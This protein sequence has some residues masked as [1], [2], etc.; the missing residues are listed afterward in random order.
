MNFQL[1]DTLRQEQYLIK[2]IIGVGGFG[3]T[4][5]A[6]HINFNHYYYVENNGILTE[7]KALK[8]INQIG[9]AL[10]KVHE[11]QTDNP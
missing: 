9:S 6:L 7:E 8:Y 2:R 3:I 10:E 11:L 5:E 1:N 4:Y